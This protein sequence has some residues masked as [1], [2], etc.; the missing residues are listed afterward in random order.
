MAKHFKK[1]T[2]AF[3][4]A[5]FLFALAFIMG[6]YYAIPLFIYLAQLPPDTV[7]GLEAG[8]IGMVEISY[9]LVSIFLSL[10]LLGFGKHRLSKTL[11]A[12]L[13]FLATFFPFLV[14]LQLITHTFYVGAIPYLPNMGMFGSIEWIVCLTLLVHLACIPL[15]AI[16]LKA[17]LAKKQKAAL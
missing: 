16:H 4:V 2:I 1:R 6:T 17:M 3:V 10:L 8:M 14:L 13:I 15:L 11:K 7:M 9:I 5:A 12:G